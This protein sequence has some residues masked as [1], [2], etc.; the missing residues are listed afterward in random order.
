[1]FLLILAFHVN[2]LTKLDII[3]ENQRSLIN[4][5]RQISAATCT[6]SD[7]VVL[8]DMILQPA[9]TDAELA[10]LNNMLSVKDN[11]KKCVSVHSSF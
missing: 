11:L 10:T 8:D 6:T 9:D 1:V 4:I 5:V 7:D 3:L 2:V